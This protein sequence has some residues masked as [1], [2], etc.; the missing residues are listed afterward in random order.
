M[1]LFITNTL[2]CL[3]LSKAEYNE[4][5]Y[6][7]YM[8][9]PRRA[10]IP[11]FWSLRVQCMVFE[12]ITFLWVQLSNTRLHGEKFIKI[13]VWIAILIAIWIASRRCTRLHG[14]C[15]VQYN[16]SASHCCSLFSNCYIAIQLI[17]GLKWCPP[18]TLAISSG[19]RLS[20]DRFIMPYVFGCFQFT[21]TNRLRIVSVCGGHYLDRDPDWVFTRY[22]ISWSRSRSG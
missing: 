3:T 14:T 2:N 8:R 19:H 1:L 4:I 16:K 17:S 13:A 18:H 9:G 11:L 12:A 10:R 5:I 15:I 22:K 20:G 21:R 7:L 6:K